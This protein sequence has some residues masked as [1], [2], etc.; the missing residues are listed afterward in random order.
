[1]PDVIKHVH[2]EYAK[3]LAEKDQF[4]EANQGMNELFKINNMFY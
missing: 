2:L 1:M 3:W 4:V